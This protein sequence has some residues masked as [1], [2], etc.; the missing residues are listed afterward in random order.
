M[1]LRPG[2]VI[3]GLTESG[4][5]AFLSDEVAPNLLELEGAAV[6]Q[7]L[8]LGSPPWR[9]ADGAVD[10]AAPPSR[11]PAGGLSVQLVRLD[12]ATDESWLRGDGWRHVDTQDVTVVLEGRLVVGVETGEHVLGPGETVVQRGTRHR[13][14]AD[15]GPVV[16]LVVHMAPDPGAAGAA[17]LVVGR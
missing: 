10:S 14:R 11:L 12:P 9:E 6:A 15:G 13:L 5:A 17:P 7:L 4:E 16:A 2:V 3:T 1:S 8:R